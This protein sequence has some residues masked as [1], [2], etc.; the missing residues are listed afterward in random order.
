[1]AEEIKKKPSGQPEP[2]S[3][4]TDIEP[5]SDEALEEIAGGLSSDS[6]C[7]CAGCSS[8]TA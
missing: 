1:M 8:K 7:S 3:K 5:L 6:C 4:K 2:D